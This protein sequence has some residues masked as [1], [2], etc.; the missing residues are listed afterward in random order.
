MILR[1]YLDTQPVVA[2]SYLLGCGGRGVGAVVDPLDDPAP[3]LRDAD[4]LGLRIAY[5]ID[6][7]VHADH[8]S[9]GRRL[10]QATGATVSGNSSPIILA[11][12]PPMTVMT[13]AVSNLN[14]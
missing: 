1:Q 9:G 10:A 5:V 12:N 7:H 14:R 3:Y 4:A 2:A 13:N 6:T 8:I 11:A